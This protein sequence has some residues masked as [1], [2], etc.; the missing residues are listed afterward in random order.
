MNLESR[1]VELEDLG[2][3]VQVHGRKVGVRE[4][5]KKIDEL[6]VKAESRRSSLVVWLITPGRELGR[7]QLF[8]KRAKRKPLQGSRSNGLRFRIVLRGGNWAGDRFEELIW[9][10]GRGAKNTKF[11][12]I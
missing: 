7:R 10:E 5:C 6:S 12:C 9:T 8:Y 3:Q 2:R 4:M 1:M 11:P